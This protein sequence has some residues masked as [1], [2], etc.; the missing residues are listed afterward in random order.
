[1]K[2]RQSNVCAIFYLV[3]AY[4]CVNREEKLFITDKNR[5]W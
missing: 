2:L 1:M 3:K 4:D 5:N